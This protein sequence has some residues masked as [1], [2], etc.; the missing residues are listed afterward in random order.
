MASA[1]HLCDCPMLSRSHDHG[2]PQGLFSPE[3]QPP[4]SPAPPPDAIDVE[5]ADAAAAAAIRASHLAY[6]RAIG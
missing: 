4:S 3:Q 6:R 2:P 5:A 1:S